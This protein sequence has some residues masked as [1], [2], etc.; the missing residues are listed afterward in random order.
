MGCCG[1]SVNRKPTIKNT[2]RKIGSF[3]CHICGHQMVAQSN[4]MKCKKCKAVR[5]LK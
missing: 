4:F 3:M 2:V 1:G 5:K